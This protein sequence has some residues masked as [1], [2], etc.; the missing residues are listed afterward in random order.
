MSNATEETLVRL[1]GKGYGDEYVI[2]S[3]DITFPPGA[4]ALKVL[5]LDGSG[6]LAWT[7]PDGNVGRY[8]D[9]AFP[10]DSSCDPVDLCA[11]TIHG[12]AHATA[13]SAALTIRVRQ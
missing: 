7:T 13:P 4:P 9:G 2:G 11:A 8:G 3:A 5:V 1:A 6:A 10:L 12:T